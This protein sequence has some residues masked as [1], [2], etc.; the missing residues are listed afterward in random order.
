M[1]DTY[2]FFYCIYN[3]IGGQCTKTGTTDI[4]ADSQYVT[5][6]Y[7]CNGNGS[8]GANVILMFQGGTLNVMSQ[9]GL[10]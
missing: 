2:T 10:R 6:S 9:R 5:V 4:G 7:G 1:L 3:I 8:V